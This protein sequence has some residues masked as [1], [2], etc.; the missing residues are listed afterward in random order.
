MYSKNLIAGIVQPLILKLLQENDRMYGYEI[1]QKMKEL[2]E[3]KIIITEGALYPA[4]HKMEMDGTLKVEKE[5]VG[6]RV[7]KYYLLSTGGKKLAEQRIEELFDFLK[8]INTILT[9]KTLS[10]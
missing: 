9:S 1:T 8:S 5:F 4:L 10:T 2:S 3:G 7:R 6:K